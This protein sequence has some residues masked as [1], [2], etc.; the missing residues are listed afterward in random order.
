MVGSTL[1]RAYLTK[2]SLAI[3]PEGQNQVQSFYIPM[4]QC[5]VCKRR[6]TLKISPECT[7]MIIINFLCLETNHIYRNAI[8]TTLYELKPDD[9]RM[10]LRS[11]I[12]F[13]KHSYFSYQRTRVCLRC[14]SKSRRWRRHQFFKA[15]RSEF[16][17]KK[18]IAFSWYPLTG[19]VERKGMVGICPNRLLAANITVFQPRVRQGR[20]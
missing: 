6:A 14:T 5:A 9:L 10:L 11:L 2:E 3:R 20:A 19:L 13:L 8:L 16:R 17:L 18:Q 7:H 1:T 15:F 12:E 4:S